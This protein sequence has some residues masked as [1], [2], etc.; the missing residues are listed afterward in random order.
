MESTTFRTQIKS[1]PHGTQIDYHSKIVLFGSCF[2]E[3]IGTKLS[4]YKFKED[5]NPYGV[6]FN[7][8][9]IADALLACVQKRVYQEEDLFYF[10]ELWHSFAHHSDFSN[11]NKQV[12]LQQ[13]NT[14]VETT[15]NALKEA[16]HLILTLGTAWV[17]KERNSGRMVANCHKVPQ[18]EFEKVLLGPNEIAEVLQDIQEKLLKL[19]PDLTIIYTVSPV[20]HLKDGFSENAL[21]KAHLLTAVHTCKQS[22]AWYFPSYEILMD[23]LRD[24][25]FYQKDLLHP[26]ELAVDY[27]WS[28][29]N[30]Y[31]VASSAKPIQKEVE[32]IQ[33]GMA[34]RPLNERTEAHLKFKNQLKEKMQKMGTEYGI[35]F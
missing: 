1:V 17:Y 6:L 13:M 27:I 5:T 19:N 30:N 8:V 31:W 15:H 26:N 34:H 12:A 22:N 11:T 2:S 32:N 23:D 24:Y 7:P 29:F 25:R 14:V 9:S 28:V 4:Y 33:K 18:K 10:N 21:S 20:R 3:N 35:Q 16:S